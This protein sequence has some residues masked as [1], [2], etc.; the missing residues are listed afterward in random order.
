MN[1]VARAIRELNPRL[2]RITANSVSTAPT[3]ASADGVVFD[4]PLCSLLYTPDLD[5][6]H[7]IFVVRPAVAANIPAMVGVDRLLVPGQWQVKGTTYDDAE[8]VLDATGIMLFGGC[9]V[10]FFVRGGRIVPV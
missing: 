5:G 1:Y 8:L 2:L 6:F 10:H 9:N 3:L 4:C 7:R